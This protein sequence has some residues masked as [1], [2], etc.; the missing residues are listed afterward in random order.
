MSDE[1][2]GQGATSED[3][4]LEFIERNTVT[5]NDAVAGETVY[6]GAG[7]GNDG[8]TGGSPREVEPEFHEHDEHEDR[9]DAPEDLDDDTP[10]PGDDGL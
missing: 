10:G 8:P 7:E 9:N 5:T 2:Q 6:P 4:L 3:E 1:N